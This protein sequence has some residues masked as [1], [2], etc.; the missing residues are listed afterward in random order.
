M[1]WKDED[2][3]LITVYHENIENIKIAVTTYKLYAHAGRVNESYE[4]LDVNRYKKDEIDNCLARTSGQ[5]F[6][7][8][9]CIPINMPGHANMLI[10]DPNRKE[11][12]HFDPHGAN[13]IGSNYRKL[14]RKIEQDT[15]HI[16]N[17]LFPGYTYVA[18]SSASNFQA[19]LNYR[20]EDSI[21][22]GTCTVW[23]LWYAYLRLSNP[24]RE[25][26]DII[27]YARE[28]LQENDFSGLENFII[29]FIK[30]MISLIGDSIQQKDNHYMILGRKI[31]K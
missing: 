11:I 5:T 28:L 6:L 17:L 23:S 1:E 29:K 27:G 31:L 12:E 21:Y 19:E 26:E 18:R 16:C 25:R 7:P 15:R 10:A 8:L 14:N 20:F 9:I 4:V 3:A 24:K 30:Q 22:A 13:F 2:N